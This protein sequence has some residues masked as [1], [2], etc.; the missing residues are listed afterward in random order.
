[1]G[2]QASL[3]HLRMAPRKVRLV[4][5]MIRGKQV[6]DAL[7]ILTFSKKSAARPV[8]KLLKSA[9]ANA[10]V[11]GGFNLDRLLV[12]TVTVDEGPTLRRWLPRAMGRA[13]RI[14]KRTSHVTLIL[15][16]GK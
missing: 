7:N 14:H 3:R 6:E 15:V 13:T 8:A 9:V 10:D 12:D 4:I 2:P 1:M 11:K 16:E 5:D